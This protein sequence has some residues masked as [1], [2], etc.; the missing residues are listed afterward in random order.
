MSRQSSLPRSRGF[1]LIEV[2]IA[3]S[4]SLLVLTGAISVGVY[5]Q[6][7]GM[8]EER[9]MEVQNAGRA[10][11]DLLVPAIQ[12]AGA[13]FGKARLHI[14]N[15]SGQLDQ[16]YAIWVTTNAQFTG[17]STFAPPSGVYASRI[18]DA[19]E[20]WDADS[21]RS[22]P[23]TKA[24]GGGVWNGSAVCTNN[25]PDSG[26]PS[27]SFAV[28]THP[29]AQVACVGVVG[30]TTVGTTIS[31][32]AGVPDRALPG[33]SEC[34]SNTT[35]GPP[36]NPGAPSE[37]LLM[38]LNV[39][40]YRVNWIT[41]RPVLEED[42]DGSAGP[43]TYQPMAQDIE[44][45]K[46]RLGLQDLT[47]LAATDFTFFPDAATGNPAV[48]T[49]AANAANNTACWAR[50]PGGTTTPMSGTLR[51]VGSAIDELMR[52]VR[53]VELSI[54]ARTQQPDIE[55]VQNGANGSTNDD[56]G[57]PVDGYKRRRFIQRVYPRNFALAGDGA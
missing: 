34:A 15:L 47:N 27:N 29:E 18:S 53:I 38:P 13:G 32:T 56:E 22:L 37:T 57:N 10:A 5:L 43:L 33:S 54:T 2:M 12:R 28:V 44:R 30:A 1:T 42:A 31:W 23:L 51:G 25:T 3:S 46:V 48:D 11:R 55:A 20:I 45:I 52:R 21:S 50:I 9:T 49:C 6:R 4:L 16:R 41:G 36:Y 39:R 17:D 7:R 8:M 24:C 14:G 26:I 35:A 40:A 19:I